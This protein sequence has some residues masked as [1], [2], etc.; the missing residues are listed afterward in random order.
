[1]LRALQAGDIGWIIHRQGLLY[2]QEYGWD[3]NYDGLVAE[4][5]V[6]FGGVTATS[7]E[8][9]RSLR[10]ILCPGSGR[11]AAHLPRGP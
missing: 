5:L 10:S 4:I 11:V 7:D 6:G 1:M 3:T 2:A 8:S 9:L